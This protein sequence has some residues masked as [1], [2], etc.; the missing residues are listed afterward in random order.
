MMVEGVPH[1][2]MLLNLDSFQTLLLATFEPRDILLP[3][4]R[5]VQRLQ[6]REACYRKDLLYL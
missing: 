1:R 2:D 5:C 6:G 4:T 3:R